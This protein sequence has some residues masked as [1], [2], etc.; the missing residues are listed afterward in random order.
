MKHEECDASSLA[1][2]TSS[3]AALFQRTLAL[4][5]CGAQD[6]RDQTERIVGS[7]LLNVGGIRKIDTRHANS[8]ALFGQLASESI[9]FPIF[10][11]L[12]I[13]R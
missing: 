2:R 7:L 13:S 10:A 8:R 12:G 3:S 9:D 6:D 4:A 5:F 1:R 11:I